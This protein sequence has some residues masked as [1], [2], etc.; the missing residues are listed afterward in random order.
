MGEKV[1]RF[2][3]RGIAAIGLAISLFLVFYS[4]RY[5][6]V[7]GT[8]SENLSTVK[9]NI[10]K[11]LL[12]F[13]LIFLVSWMLGAVGERLSDKCIG[14]L[15]MFAAGA[16]MCICIWIAINANC[17][18]VGDQYHVYNGAVSMARGEFPESKIGEYL[19]VY[20]FQYG[21][22]FIFSLLYRLAR[23]DSWL[24]VH[25]VQAMCMGGTVYMGYKVLRLLFH[26][27]RAEV[28]YLCNMLLFFPMYLY[29][30]FI[31]GECIGILFSEIAIYLI[32]KAKRMMRY[33][34][35]KRSA[36]Y[37]MGVGAM[38]VAYVS[39]SALLIFMIAIFICEGLD[40]VFDK[41]WLVV[42]LLSSI[43]IVPLIGQNSLFYEIGKK[44]GITLDHALPMD[45]VVAMALQGN[46]LDEKIPGSYNEYNWNTFVSVNYDVE[47]ASE[48][49]KK[50]IMESI[51]AWSKNPKEM[52]AFF[53]RK[54]VSQW[55]EPT[56]GAFTM[57][58]YMLEPQKWVT[59]IYYGKWNER[60]RSFLNQYQVAIYFGVLGYYIRLLQGKK[61]VEEYLLGLILIGGFLFSLIWETKSRYVF[62]YMFVAVWCATVGMK[63]YIEI[64]MSVAERWKRKRR[65]G[66]TNE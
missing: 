25:I 3:L 34:M 21:P 54:A 59:E 24:V 53:K 16:V 23:T 9:D 51:S 5:T 29:S 61:E 35:W 18:P 30:M 42:I 15:A 50:S 14:I 7:M 17:Y 63:W 44:T 57:T 33:T 26:S 13:V 43:L 48:L 2:C 27:K 40:A 12:V 8:E 4:W 46:S 6:E 37:L 28:I 41:K 49:A 32:L 60:I 38:T 64:A 31:Y 19:S 1:K 66:A 11:H 58:R 39:R 62:P 45:L 20:S 65:G 47:K 22:I 56:Y 52:V 10:W 55:N 36:L